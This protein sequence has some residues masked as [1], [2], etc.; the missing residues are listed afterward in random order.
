[1]TK[2]L[3]PIYPWSNAGFPADRIQGGLFASMQH[4]IKAMVHA[5]FDVTLL[6][7]KN[8]PVTDSRVKQIACDFLSKEEVGTIKW[9]SFSEA[10]A[11]HG[12]KYDLIWSN[13][14][15]MKIEKPHIR[16]KF[17]KFVSRLV[18]IMHH[19]DEI[20]FSTFFVSQYQAMAW[21]LENG[22]RVAAVSKTFKDAAKLRFEVKPNIITNNP[23]HVSD[24]PTHFVDKFEWFNNMWVEE[25]LIEGELKSNGDFVV[26]GRCS[27]EKKLDVAIQAFIQSGSTKRLHVFTNEPILE[28]KQV[29]YYNKV[30]ALDA[31][32]IVWH[33]NEQREGI[34]KV[35]RESSVFIFPSSKEAS[36]LSPMEAASCGCKVIYACPNCWFLGDSGVQVDNYRV[37][38][39]T[40]AINNIITPTVNEKE[41]AR[42][43]LTLEGSLEAYAQRIVDFVD[44]A[45]VG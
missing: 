17:E 9:T 38:T 34:F 24:L 19:Y 22:G 44:Y 30:R 5:G 3:F 40:K 18:I 31:P 10:I 7:S 23:Y 8:F 13:F 6:T 15:E 4:Q 2:V 36:P 28:P 32:N 33:I 27:K 20:P 11:E 41:A 16:E 1:M 35:L 43:R 42:V 29:E 25:S 45:P 12:D 37:P 39:F 14:P 26:L 21:V